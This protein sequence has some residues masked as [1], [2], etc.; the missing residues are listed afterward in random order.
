MVKHRDSGGYARVARKD[1]HHEFR[2]K[3]EIENR[4][5]RPLALIHVLLGKGCTP[6]AQLSLLSDDELDDVDTSLSLHL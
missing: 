3:T 5:V 4:F 2:S 1:Y 6:E